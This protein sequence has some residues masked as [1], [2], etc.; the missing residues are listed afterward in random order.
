MNK[1]SIYII[2]ILIVLLS[3]LLY[4]ATRMYTSSIMAQNGY[5]ISK[6]KV[7][8][9]LLSTKNKI[10]TRNVN[11]EKMSKED[12]VFYSLGKNYVANNNKKKEI[13]TKYPIYSND[14]LELINIKQYFYL[15]FF[16]TYFQLKTW[17][18]PS[19]EL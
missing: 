15:L 6:N 2:S 1:K 17:Q 5:F 18:D 12:T 19:Q 14:G 7:E 13:N 4:F 3:G 8:K 10:K 16:F 9:E 11:L